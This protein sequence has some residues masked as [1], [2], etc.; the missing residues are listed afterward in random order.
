M[1]KN[2]QTTSK[3]WSVLSGIIMI[4]LAVFFFMNPASA[5]IGIY[6]YIAVTILMR[7]F[8]S[9]FLFFQAKNLP[10]RGL[11]LA[12]GIIDILFGFL[13]FNQPLVGTI[14]VAY[15]IGFW[16]MF[17]SITTLIMSFEI[18]KINQGNWWIYL[19]MGVLGIITS[20]IVFNNPFA[21]LLSVTVMIGCYLVFDGFLKIF[22]A[23][24]K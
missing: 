2:T 14:T 24:K 13:F 6:L 1:D 20:F 22:A 12:S 10:H 18:K 11:I 7:G 19:L 16:I 15:M 23:F 4:I 9:V 17:S 3:L 8:A 21:T 5:L